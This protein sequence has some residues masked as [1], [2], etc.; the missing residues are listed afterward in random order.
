[1]VGFV[2]NIP[3]IT[4]QSFTMTE[5]QVQCFHGVQEKHY[6]VEETKAFNTGKVK[7]N[8]IIAH[9]QIQAEHIEGEIPLDI[10]NG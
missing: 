8:K 2:Q 5:H 1:M 9:H 4:G 3:R 7:Y 10:S 6:D